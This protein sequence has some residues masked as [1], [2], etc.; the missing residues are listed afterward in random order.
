MELLHALA[1]RE[2]L[3]NSLFA[4]R[5]RIGKL[6]PECLLYYANQ[7]ITSDRGAVIGL[8]IGSD[9]LVEIANMVNVIPQTQDSSKPS[10]YHG[11]S[12]ARR[13]RGGD[14]AYVALAKESGGM[15]DK[16]IYEVQSLLI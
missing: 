12:E 11:G 13:E 3:G 9:E 1:Y 15:K 14:M 5:Y 16:L 8:G 6:S 10:Q 4:S 7:T 2:G